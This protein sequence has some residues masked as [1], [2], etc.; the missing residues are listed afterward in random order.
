MDKSDYLQLKKR[1]FEALTTPD[2]NRALK[3][4]VFRT[5]DP[6]FDD[7]RA[8]LSYMG[9]GLHVHLR[10]TRR[11]RNYRPLVYAAVA[12]SIAIALF[13]GTRSGNKNP[14]V[15]PVPGTHEDILAMERTLTHIFSHTHTDIE[16]QLS[17]F[18]TP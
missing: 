1:Y 18:F 8:V 9:T 15:Q 2:E 5:D 4:F 14:S 17:N 3:A 7:V 10:Q 16:S 12:A 11:R 13:V 6:D